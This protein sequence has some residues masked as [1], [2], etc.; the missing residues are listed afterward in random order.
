MAA[1]CCEILTCTHASIDQP[2]IVRRLRH[3]L[4]WLT[5]LKRK[6]H[7]LTFDA[8]IFKGWSRTVQNATGSAYGFHNGTHTFMATTQSHKYI[9]TGTLGAAVGG[10]PYSKVL[11]LLYRRQRGRNRGMRGRGGVNYSRMQHGPSQTNPALQGERNK[12]SVCSFSKPLQAL[13]EPLN[14]L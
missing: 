13:L 2:I 7:P 14:L 8:P 11:K 5:L 4:S 9:Q 3:T 1:P 12:C 6:G 10:G